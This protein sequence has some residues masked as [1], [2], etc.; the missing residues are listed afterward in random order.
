MYRLVKPENIESA[1]IIY[2]VTQFRETRDDRWP[3]RVEATC[4]IIRP[5]DLALRRAT[6]FFAICP[7]ET[8]DFLSPEETVCSLDKRAGCWFI[9]ALCPL[10][11]DRDLRS[12]SIQYLVQSQRNLFS[13]VFS[14]F[15]RPRYYTAFSTYHAATELIIAPLCRDWSVGHDNARWNDNSSQFVTNESPV[16]IFTIFTI[17]VVILLHS[18]SHALFCRYR[19]K[20][21]LRS[22]PRYLTKCVPKTTPTLTLTIVDKKKE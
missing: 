10:T 6:H 12:K 19:R 3:S 14:F 22:F 1:Y 21:Y 9:N 18:R 8:Y 17:F 16:I 2:N 4:K 5:T 7:D 20:L 11:V 13:L 15:N